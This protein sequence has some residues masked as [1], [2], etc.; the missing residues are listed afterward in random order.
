MENKDVSLDRKQF[1][2]HPDR[3]FQ[4]TLETAPVGANIAD[5]Y[6][7]VHT[8]TLAIR[9]TKEH[10]KVPLFE[11]HALLVKDAGVMPRVNCTNVAYF[12]RHL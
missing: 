8:V 11:T 6:S 9:N 4:H 7:F 10:I 2:K 12:Y 3:G 5:A 1:P